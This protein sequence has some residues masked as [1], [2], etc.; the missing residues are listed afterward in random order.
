MILL[1]VIHLVAAP[2]HIGWV[3]TQL[4]PQHASLAIAGT[5]L[6]H[7]L[8]G[9]LLL[10]LGISTWWAARSL[11]QTWALRVATMNAIVLFSLPI[12]LV[13]IMLL[14]AA[15]APLFRFAILV[16]MI[17]CLSETL[18]LTGVWSHSKQRT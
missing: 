9:I 13:T 6:N 12:L 3:A 5:R 11:T 10:P 15:N 18:A 8:V 1:G 14:E 7:I 4:R 16:L 17:A 2:F